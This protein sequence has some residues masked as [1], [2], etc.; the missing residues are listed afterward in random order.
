MDFA[1]LSLK[2]L[3]IGYQKPIVNQINASMIKGEIH[4]FLGLNGS[5]KSTLFKTIMGLIPPLKGSIFWNNKPLNPKELSK[6]ASYIHNWN[7]PLPNCSVFEYVSFGRIPYLSGLGLLSE[8]DKQM[9]N[10]SLEYCQCNALKNQSLITLSDGQLQKVRFARAVCQS[11][12]VLLFDEPT[13]FLDQENIL[14]LL[15]RLSDLKTNQ[16]KTILIATHRLELFRS[17]GNYMHR[18]ENGRSKPFTL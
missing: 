10:D 11:T 14:F 18:F 4:L 6:K 12:D 15:D 7:N 1:K 13:I 2:Q 16:Q 5:G 3:S 9:V 17:I 8:R